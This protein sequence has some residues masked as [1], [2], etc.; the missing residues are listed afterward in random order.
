MGKFQKAMWI[1]KNTSK[2]LSYSLLSNACNPSHEAAEIKTKSSFEGFHS[3]GDGH[4]TCMRSAWDMPI[5][6]VL[7]YTALL[8]FSN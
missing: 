3:I 6:L 4:F 8:I 5:T 2:W 7:Y 1:R